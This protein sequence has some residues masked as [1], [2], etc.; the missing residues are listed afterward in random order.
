MRNPGHTLIE[1]LVVLA[2]LAVLLGV[3]LPGMSRWRDAAAVR[4]ARDELAAGLAWTR[5]AAVTHGGASLVLDPTTGRFTI[6]LGDGADRPAVD[7]SGQYGVVIDPGTD[8]LVAFRYD[9]L[10]IGRMTSRTVRVRRG[11][12]EG[13]V[14]V[15]A[16]GR[17]RRW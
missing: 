12:I 1:I 7:L 15:S 14:T 11:H 4:A 16:Y 9:A 3:G 5:M 17:Y 10:G 13:G 2:I 8:R 6:G